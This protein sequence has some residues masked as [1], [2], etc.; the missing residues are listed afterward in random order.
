[1]TIVEFSKVISRIFRGILDQEVLMLRMR[2]RQRVIALIEE[3]ASEVS[4][5]V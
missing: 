2:S 4:T 3:L 5:I 1:M